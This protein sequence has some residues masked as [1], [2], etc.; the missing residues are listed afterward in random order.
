M[1]SLGGKNNSVNLSAANTSLE[2]E[3]C[4]WG[5]KMENMNKD[6]LQK[7]QSCIYYNMLCL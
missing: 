5:G 6:T 1:V 4:M 3:A 2:F 7:R